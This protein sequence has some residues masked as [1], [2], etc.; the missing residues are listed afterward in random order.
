MKTLKFGAEGY[1]VEWNGEFW[2]TV[3]PAEEAHLTQLHGS[4]EDALA[5]FAQVKPG[6]MPEVIR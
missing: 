3:F 2:Q 4:I 1:F 5:Y 6:V